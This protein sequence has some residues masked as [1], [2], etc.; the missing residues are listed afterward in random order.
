MPEFDF[1]PVDH[2]PFAPAGDDPLIVP[3]HIMSPSPR[4]VAAAHGLVK[5]IT[6]WARLPGRAMMPQQP[7]VPGQWSDVDE[8]IR[9]LDQ[10]AKMD[11]AA[12]TALG[13]V[14]LPGVPAGAVGIGAG[15]GI[16]G[17]PKLAMD[18]ASRMARAKEMG[19]RTDM[20]LA[21]GSANEFTAFDPAQGGATSAAAPARMGVWTEVAP[22][23]GIADEFA[24]TAA[25]RSGGN[26]QIFPLYH[27]TDKPAV[28]QLSGDEKNHEIAATLADAWDRGYDAAMLRNYNSPGGKM[29]DILV[30]RDPS[31]LRSPFAAF[32]PQKKHSSNLLAGIAGSGIA[33]SAA[34]YDLIPVDHDPFA[35]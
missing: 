34:G 24:Q 29:G 22:F 27:R 8:S 26:A 32:D 10:Q 25:Q 1:V 33:G 21:H 31:Q 7:L 30:V 14:G 23:R 18:Q 4:A 11:W 17:S 19:F 13:M 2:D 35:Q 12:S 9:Q 15:K 28:I 5:G 20:P 3:E 16:G 6:D